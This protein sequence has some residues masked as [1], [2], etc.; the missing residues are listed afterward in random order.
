M[1][2]EEE[3]TICS[4]SIIFAAEDDAAAAEEVIYAASSQEADCSVMLSQRADDTDRTEHTVIQDSGVKSLRQL[5]KECIE[6]QLEE[7]D[8]EKEKALNEPYSNDVNGN[9][10]VDLNTPESLQVNDTPDVPTLRNLCEATI[11]ENRAELPVICFVTDAEDAETTLWQADSGGKEDNEIYLCLN[12]DLIEEELAQIVGE[13]I[14]ESPQSPVPVIEAENEAESV[15]SDETRSDD[16]DE[17]APKITAIEPKILPLPVA[18]IV[19]PVPEI[20]TD[21][22]DSD[23]GSSTSRLCLVTDDIQSNIQY[24]ETVSQAFGGDHFMVKIEPFKKYLQKK[25]VQTSNYFKMLIIHR[26]L[27]KYIIYQRHSPSKRAQRAAAVTAAIA[28]RKPKQEKKKKKKQKRRSYFTKPKRRSK[29]VKKA[30]TTIAS[31]AEETTV[32]PIKIRILKSAESVPIEAEICMNEA[33]TLRSNNNVVSKKSSKSSPSRNIPAPAPPKIEPIPFIKPVRSKKLSPRRRFSIATS[34]VFSFIAPSI[35]VRGKQ[36]P[37]L[38]FPPPSLTIPTKSKCSAPTVIAPPPPTKSSKSGAMPAV[39]TTE[40]PKLSPASNTTVNQTLPVTVNPIQSKASTKSWAIPAIPKFSPSCHSSTATST[41]SVSSTP[42]SKK[43]EPPKMSPPSCLS[44]TKSTVSIVTATPA[45]AKAPKRRASTAIPTKAAKKFIEEPKTSSHISIETPTITVA[46][47]TTTPP[48]P[49]TKSKTKSSTSSRTMSAIKTTP[50]PCYNTVSSTTPAIVKLLE[51]EISNSSRATPAIKTPKIAPPRHSPTATSTVTTS[52]TWTLPASKKIEPPKLSPPCCLSSTKSSVSI[53]SS[54]PA[55]AKQPK[56]RESTSVPTKAALKFN[57]EPKFPCIA[58]STIAIGTMPP[59]TTTK[60]K[61]SWP[62][63]APPEPPIY[64]TSYP[65]SNEKSPIDVTTTSSTIAKLAKRRASST[66]PMKITDAPRC[67]TSTATSPIL[68]KSET[69]ASIISWAMH[70]SKAVPSHFPAITSSTVLK[71]TL[72]IHIAGRSMAECEETKETKKLNDK[73]YFNNNKLINNNQHSYR[74]VN[75]NDNNNKILNTK[76]AITCDILERIAKKRIVKRRLTMID[77]Y[78]CHDDNYNY[79]TDEDISDMLSSYINRSIEQRPLPPMSLSPI[80]TTT[81]TSLSPPSKTSFERAREK[82][83]KSIAAKHECATKKKL[84]F[85]QC[86]TWTTMET[87]AATKA[88]PIAT[89]MVSPSSTATS[90]GPTMEWQRTKVDNVKLAKMP[91]SR[92]KSRAKSTSAKQN[93]Q[94]K[95][96]REVCRDATR[97]QRN[98]LHK[99]AKL[100]FGEILLNINNF[101]KKMPKTERTCTKSSSSSSRSSTGSKSNSPKTKSNNFAMR[102]RANSSSSESTSTVAS[103]DDSSSTSTTTSNSSTWSNEKLRESVKKCVQRPAQIVTRSQIRK[104]IVDMD[105]MSRQAKLC[106]AYSENIRRNLNLPPEMPDFVMDRYL[107]QGNEVSSSSECSEMQKDK[108]PF[109]KLY[110][111]RFI[112]DLAMKYERNQ[113]LTKH[114]AIASRKRKH[115]HI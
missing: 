85:G 28:R 101:Y 102:S 72:P 7:H 104:P 89:P 114:S 12:G 47:T 19:V 23:D 50:P 43:I 65:F 75:D 74:N 93:T 36:F 80:S 52:A 38:S 81:T 46:T 26:L 62:V 31:K 112:D 90:S 109:V 108:E 8:N 58:K 97:Y 95:Q 63:I 6:H 2:T 30:L 73:F 37:P 54:S 9:E 100:N 67:Y 55:I 33:Q 86:S 59:T 14:S 57:N 71:S 83:S 51:A 61:P 45:T 110:R 16:G 82:L 94:E 96:I 13:S 77:A 48:S 11:M 105:E 69:E 91:M 42:A 79:D 35:T 4:V 113:S 115:H 15:I 24:E 88:S 53:I 103:S 44:S 32:K 20:P 60:S 76:P 1:Q 87:T 27:K 92:T 111:N 98:I 68:A 56:R 34:T 66:N 10:I 5:A 106:R 41:S 78:R 3:I 99:F 39:R 17:I 22:Y 40:P 84:S 70:T 64:S 49:T 18:A 29:L 25:Y 107:S 21:D